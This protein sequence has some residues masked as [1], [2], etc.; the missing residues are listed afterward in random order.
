MMKGTQRGNTRRRSLMRRRGTPVTRHPFQHPQSTQ[1]AGLIFIFI[2]LLAFVFLY[3]I[4]DKPSSPCKIKFPEMYSLIFLQ[5]NPP[6]SL[7]RTIARQ[8][9]ER[10]PAP[11]TCWASKALCVTDPAL[12]GQVYSVLMHY[13]K[14]GQCEYIRPW[15]NW[16]AWQCYIQTGSRSAEGTRG[17]EGGYRRDPNVV[18]NVLLSL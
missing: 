2:F 3:V 8:N 1:L 10:V 5:R 14:R 11:V 16:G 12:S 18:I 6:F 7:Q 17:D 13:K 4:Y 15:M 9:A